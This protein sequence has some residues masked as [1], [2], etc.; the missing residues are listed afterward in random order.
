MHNSIHQGHHPVTDIY[1]IHQGHYPLPDIYIFD[2]H[3][4]SGIHLTCGTVCVMYMP[5]AMDNAQ[6]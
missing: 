3:N 5:Q 1:S 4:I 2:I 6:Q